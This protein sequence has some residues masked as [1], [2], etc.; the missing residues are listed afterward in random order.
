MRSGLGSQHALYP[1]WLIV[2]KEETG[3]KSHLKYDM[4]KKMELLSLV[5]NQ[6]CTLK[7]WAWRIPEEKPGQI[8]LCT[9]LLQTAVTLAGAT[10][11]TRLCTARL[12]TV[13]SRGICVGILEQ[14]HRTWL[15]PDN[16][17]VLRRLFLPFFFLSLER[18]PVVFV[19]QILVVKWRTDSSTYWQ[20]L[21]KFFLSS[22]TSLSIN[23]TSDLQMSLQCS[24]S[25]EYTDNT[26]LALWCPFTSP[27][28][29]CEKLISM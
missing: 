4:P 21:C 27:Q 17:V 28:L 8:R 20:A 15:F 13:Y 29:E 23:L 7:L 3:R 5:Q 19:R 12:E 6:A 9:P 11:Q 14:N 22:H 1:K 25:P 24:N 16:V 18:R 10:S 2:E 26:V